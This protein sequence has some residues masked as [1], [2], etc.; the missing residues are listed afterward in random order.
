MRSPDGATRSIWTHAVPKYPQPPASFPETIDVCVVGAGIAGVTTA[1]LLAGEGKGVVVVDE[2]PIGGGQTSRTSA[3]LASALDDRFSHVEKLLGVDAIK[4]VYESHAAAIDHIESI[5]EAEKIDCAFSRL[6]AYLMLAD[7]DSPKLLE[8]ELAAAHRAGFE[9]ASLLRTVPFHPEIGHAIRFPNQ[10]RFE[11]MKYLI[12]LARA[13]NA[14]GMQ[15]FVGKRVVDAKGADP[16][17]RDPCIITFEDQSTL[18]ADSVIVATNTPAPIND[19][20]GVYT[21]QASYRTYMIGLEIPKGATGDALYWDTADPYHY[22]RLAHLD[23]SDTDVLLVGGEDHKV[24]QPGASRERFDKLEGWARYHFHEAGKRVREWSGQVQE[25]ADGIAFIGKA[26]TAGD[27]VYCITGDSGMGLTHGT[28]GAMLVRDLILGRDN[29]WTSLYDP[30]RKETNLDFVKE[31]L[32]VTAQYADYI[33]PGD[34]KDETQIRPNSGAVI[35]EGSKKLAVYRDEDGKLHKHS[36]ICTHL[37]C[38]VNW[39]DVEQSWDCPCHGSRF[40][41]MG[42]VLMGPAVDDLPKS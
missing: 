39:N 11:P 41:P 1:Y 30:A 4:T 40:D 5:V 7:D 26:P 2:G 21:K 10:A 24:G 14:R 18:R 13:G 15:I 17:K 29:P 38:I 28:L 12:G 22:A 33:T 3:H 42:R 36:A 27:N 23:E 25:P 37:Y 8:D 34:V 32:N 31:N 9:G 19:W 35:R 6:D 16:K 20:A